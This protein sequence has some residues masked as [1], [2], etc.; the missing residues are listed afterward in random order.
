MKLIYNTINETI[1]PWPRIDAEPVV[2]LEPNLLEMT[3]IQENA[4]TY[5]ADTQMLA[6]TQTIDIEA[7]TVTRGWKVVERVTL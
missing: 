2:G 4:P 1:L 6:L 3:V 5:N 7:K